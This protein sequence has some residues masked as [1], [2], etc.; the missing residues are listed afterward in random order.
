[1]V[2][3]KVWEEINSLSNVSMWEIL[4][5]NLNVSELEQP[6]GTN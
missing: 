2:F 4:L 1:M 6:P 3:W 5:Q